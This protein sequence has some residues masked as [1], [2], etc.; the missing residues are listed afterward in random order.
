MAPLDPPLGI[1]KALARR[2]LDEH[3]YSVTKEI[4]GTQVLRIDLGGLPTH[5]A[6]LRVRAFAFQHSH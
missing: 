4:R 3:L 6:R 2:I 5:K 1:L